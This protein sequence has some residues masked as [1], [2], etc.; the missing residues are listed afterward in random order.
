MLNYIEFIKN[1]TNKFIN[2][3]SDALMHKETN[4]S[5]KEEVLN[6]SITRVIHNLSKKKKMMITE[7]KTSL[8]SAEVI[9]SKSFGVLFNIRSLTQPP[10][11]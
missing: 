11:R 9:I 5:P 10:T 8:S 3:I 6:F 7:G 1:I 4:N 2:N